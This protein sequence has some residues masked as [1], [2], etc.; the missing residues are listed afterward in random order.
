MHSLLTFNSHGSFDGILT[1]TGCSCAQEIASILISRGALSFPQLIKLTALPPALV[2]ASLLV[3]STHTVLYHSETEVAG[4]LTELY[5]LNHDAIERRMRGGLY[6]EMASEW[7]GGDELSEVIDALWREGMLVRED[8]IEVVRRRIVL[9]QDT[10]AAFADL[11][12]PKGKKRARVDE[13]G[14]LPLPPPSIH[15][16]ELTDSR[17]SSSQPPKTPTSWSARRSHRASS[18]SS[19]PARS[20]RL[21]R[22]RSSGRR[23]SVQPS[24]V[25]QTSLSRTGW[26]VPSR[27]SMEVKRVEQ[28]LTP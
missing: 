28:S 16:C 13:Q 12:D 22:L 9:K 1:F 24:R 7:D 15:R 21:A 19:R 20:S 5:E 3:L 18:R 11:D 27:G 4:R 14:S 8:L 6:V 26:P 2:H 25:S 10:A 17:A 23:S